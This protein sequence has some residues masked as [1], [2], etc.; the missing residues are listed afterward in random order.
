MTTKAVF[1]TVDDYVDSFPADVRTILEEIRRA[2][3]RIAPEA[4]E[5]I[6]YGMPAIKLNG[7]TL[8][9]FAAWKTHIGFY[10]RPA[11][12]AE[13]EKA[14]AP[15][16]DAKDTLKFPLAQPIPYHLVVRIIQLRLQAL[17]RVGGDRSPGVASAPRTAGAALTRAQIPR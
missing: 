2:V 15:Y 13:F 17:S 6:R 16:K 14:I 11:G 7:K 5:T 1:Q 12:D 3:R 4:M 9:Y 10:D 8:I